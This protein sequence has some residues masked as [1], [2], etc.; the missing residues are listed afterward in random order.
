MLFDLERVPEPLVFNRHQRNAPPGARYIGR[1]SPFGNDFAIGAPDPETGEPMSRQRV[2]ELFEERLLADE[3]L[4]A[5]VKR[6]LRGQDLV[7]FCK[8]APCHGDVL[9]KYANE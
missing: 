2:I 8:P 9:L 3:E 4:M 7:C 6:E 5:L 1:G